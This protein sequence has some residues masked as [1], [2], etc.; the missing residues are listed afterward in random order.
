MM[1]DRPLVEVRNIAK[2]YGNVLALRDVSMVIR[3]GEVTCVLGDN[4]AGKSTL[5]KL[6]S[7][8]TRPDHGEYLIG[9]EHVSLSGPRDALNRGIATVFQDLAMIPLLSITD[10]KSV[11]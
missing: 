10:R 11:V 2:Q 4:G 8:V 3:P 5:I 7:G 1:T 9:G 6:L